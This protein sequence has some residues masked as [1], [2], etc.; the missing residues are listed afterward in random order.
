MSMNLKPVPA[1]NAFAPTYV[2]KSLNVNA[3]AITTNSVPPAVMHLKSKNRNMS[4]FA[5]YML[6]REL[7]KT[8]LTK[9]DD[10]PENYRGWKSTFK[11]TMSDLDINATEK[12]DLLIR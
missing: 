12:L 1:L 7:N 2:P 8:G 10:K 3:P 4:Q 9:F 6:R 5:K 11:A